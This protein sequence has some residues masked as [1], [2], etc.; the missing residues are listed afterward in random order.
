[1]KQLDFEVAGGRS[2]YL[3]REVTQMCQFLDIKS[4][5]MPLDKDDWKVISRIIFNLVAKG[6]F[7]HRFS[8]EAL[9]MQ[10]AIGEL[11]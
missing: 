11:N 8:E 4:L 3:L 7:A 5:A 1:M 9:R 6:N 10:E 2:P